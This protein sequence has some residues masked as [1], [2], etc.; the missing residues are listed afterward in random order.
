MQQFGNSV[1]ELTNPD[2][3]MFKM[4]CALRGK[5]IDINGNLIDLKRPLMNDKGVVAVVGMVQSVVNKVT[6]MSNL[7]KTEVPNIMRFFVYG[8]IEDLL[9]NASN[10]EVGYM[11]YDKEVEVLMEVECIGGVMVIPKKI[12]QTNIHIDKAACDKVLSIALITSYICA[13]RCF[14]E[15]ERRFL[16]RTQHEY[17]N[18]MQVENQQGGSGMGSW[19]GKMMGRN[20]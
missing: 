3:E 9:F 20:K 10:Y 6:I 16:S 17:V 11:K 8:L 2:E 1:L 12:V 5:S 13:K 7:N 15:G 18:R 14:E 4:E 19:I